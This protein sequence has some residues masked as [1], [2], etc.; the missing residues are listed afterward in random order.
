MIILVS[1]TEKYALILMSFT[2]YL[3]CYWDYMSTNVTYC[4][5]LVI[6]VKLCNKLAMDRRDQYT[7][8]HRTS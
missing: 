3:C 1:V 6:Y 5:Y 8:F 2:G 4:S 7:L